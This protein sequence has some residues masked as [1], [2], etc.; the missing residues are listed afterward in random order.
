MAGGEGEAAKARVVGR[1][2]GRG[3]ARGGELEGPD[4]AGASVPRGW[5]VEGHGERLVA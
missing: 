3:A 5:N 4:G 2:G 1:V